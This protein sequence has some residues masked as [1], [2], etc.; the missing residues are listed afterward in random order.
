MDYYRERP[1]SH[2]LLVI[3]L[4]NTVFRQLNQGGRL[5]VYFQFKVKFKVKKQ[6]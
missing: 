1:S 6:Y 4:L 5:W 2:E 3:L